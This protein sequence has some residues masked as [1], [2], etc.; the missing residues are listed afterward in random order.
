M[1]GSDIAWYTTIL[2]Q[3]LLFAPLVGVWLMTYLSGPI[4]WFHK[5]F[6]KLA[7]ISLIGPYFLYP[8]QL[9]YKSVT[10]LADSSS[11]E[12]D[13]RYLALYAVT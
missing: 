4:D 11:D 7:N 10:F 1:S 8:F 6:V 3:Q 12:Q 9:V 2:L 13:W 5:A